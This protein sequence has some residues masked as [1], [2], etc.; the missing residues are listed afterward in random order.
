MRANLKKRCFLHLFNER[1]RFSE[2]VCRF[3]LSGYRPKNP[4]KSKKNQTIGGLSDVLRVYAGMADDL[5]FSNVWSGHVLPH[6][7]HTSVVKHLTGDRGGQLKPR[8]H[9]ALIAV[10]V[11]DDAHLV[12]AVVIEQFL[13]LGA[14]TLIDFQIQ[15]SSL[16]Q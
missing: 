11:L 5:S 8:R 7:A 2:L 6:P 4:T 9:K 3:L 12:K 1:T 14:K 15:A 13:Y 10:T 16:L